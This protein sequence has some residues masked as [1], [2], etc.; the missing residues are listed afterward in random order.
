[1]KVRSLGIIASVFLWFCSG[2]ADAGPIY[3]FREPD[4][5]IR[6]SS[7]PPKD[8][9]NA[10][11]FSAEK[12]KFSYYSGK[13]YERKRSGGGGRLFRDRFH[14]IIY[15]AARQH[16]VGEDLVKAVIHVESAFNPYAVSPKGALGLMQ[17]MPE[18]IRLLKIR[19]PFAPNE[20]IDGGV[21]WLAMLIRR[22]KGDLRLV[23]AA[24]NAG[25]KAV[26]KYG[27]VPPYDE[28]QDYVSRVLIMKDRYKK[29][30][31]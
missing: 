21:K 5:A 13:V 23:L 31:A 12:A 8:G 7:S 2:S 24:Y 3:V 1:M 9:S 27:G 15:R 6:F 29:S 20:N 26:E 4:G 10:K 19:D 16:Q 18:N 30:G 17:L 22:F 28:T 14:S 11:V 25:I